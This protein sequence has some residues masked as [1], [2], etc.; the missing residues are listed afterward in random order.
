[1]ISK[2]KTWAA[3]AGVLILA[4]VTLFLRGKAAARREIELERA[5]DNATA[6]EERLRINE[7]VSRETDLVDRARRIG[8]VRDEP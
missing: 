3:F 5:K 2:L 1:M 7:S 8:V 4:A 6:L